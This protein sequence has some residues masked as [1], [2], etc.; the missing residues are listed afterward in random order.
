MR[1]A[2]KKS[3]PPTV[4]PPQ[5]DPDYEDLFFQFFRDVSRSNYFKGYF[6]AVC[7]DEM[8]A[9]CTAHREAPDPLNQY[10]FFEYRDYRGHAVAA[11][12]PNIGYSPFDKLRGV[13]FLSCKP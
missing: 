1:C 3:K 6:Q 8:K 4:K 2:T 7:L 9:E 11:T 13:H 10:L 12:F 5:T